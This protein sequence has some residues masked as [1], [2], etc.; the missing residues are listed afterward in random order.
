MSS[1]RLIT[2]SAAQRDIA[3][4]IFIGLAMGIFSTFAIMKMN[5]PFWLDES[6]SI[7]KGQLSF[8]DLVTYLKSDGHTP[9]YYLLLKAWLWVFGLSEV[10]A[11]ML[12]LLCQI[13]ATVLLFVHGRLVLRSAWAGAFAG[14]LFLMGTI[15]METALLVKMYPLIALFT[16][17][18]I[19][20]TQ[21]A[22]GTRKKFYLVLTAL[23]V[24][25]ASF[26]NGMVFFFVIG[27]IMASPIYGK[28]NWLQIT[29]SCLVGL[30]PYALLWLPIAIGQAH[31]ASIDWIRLSTPMDPIRDIYNLYRPATLLLPIIALIAAHSAGFAPWRRLINLGR[32]SAELLKDRRTLFPVLMFTASF[33]AFCVTS[34]LVKPLLGVPRYGI[35]F[36]PMLSIPVGALLDRLEN[37]MLSA[38]L[39]GGLLLLCLFP[40]ASNPRYPSYYYSKDNI[41]SV[42]QF[43]AARLQPDD[44]IVS[45]GLSYLPLKLYLDM[46]SAPP[47]THLVIPFGIETH[48][49]WSKYESRRE[50]PDD[51]PAQWERVYGI[52]QQ[53]KP[54]RVFVLS[55]ESRIDRWFTDR[56]SEHMSLVEHLGFHAQSW[57][58]RGLYVFVPT[59][60]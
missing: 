36:L 11:R 54:R 27:L 21:L 51:M 33:G 35:I 60:P 8:E 23:T 7:F 18:S 4:I 37:R 24:C 2:S 12:S 55:N 44:V 46:R 40:Y 26:T 56:F 57:F 52:I 38:V 59:E 47:H 25:A 53:E 6:C 20:T 1:S 10:S 15:A 45:V 5:H 14:T 30:M 58:V 41:A 13:G 39:L 48:P 28:I 49:G 34:F 31:N 32:A 42:A 29:S 16:V 9:L 3:P 19:I 50:A 43:L 22:V 17:L